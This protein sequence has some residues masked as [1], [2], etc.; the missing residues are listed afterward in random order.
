MDTKLAVRS[1]LGST[2]HKR[3]CSPGRSTPNGLSENP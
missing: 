3:G 1:A 2:E